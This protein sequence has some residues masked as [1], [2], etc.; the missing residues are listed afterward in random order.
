MLEMTSKKFL[1][2]GLTRLMLSLVKAWLGYDFTKVSSGSGLA[3]MLL[4]KLGLS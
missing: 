1:L 4:S 2:G 3:W